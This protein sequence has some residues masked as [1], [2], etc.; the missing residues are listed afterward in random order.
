MSRPTKRC[1]RTLLG[2][3]KEPEDSP[4]DYSNFSRE[5]IDNEYAKDFARRDEEGRLVD[6]DGEPIPDRDVPNEGGGEGGGGPSSKKRTEADMQL[7]TQVKWGTG[8]KNGYWICVHCG[9][10]QKSTLCRIK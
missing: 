1:R 5:F 4:A 2:L 3:V 7:L 10:S 6:D 9:I 8:T